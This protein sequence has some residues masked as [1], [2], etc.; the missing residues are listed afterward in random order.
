MKEDFLHYV[1]KFQKLISPRLRTVSWQRLPVLNPGLHN[2]NSGPDFFNAQLQLDGQLWAGNVEI[3]I[4]SSD[5]Y[6]HGHEKDPA[7]DSVILHVVWIHDAEV[8]R[9][10]GEVI[11][12]FEI[13]D[14]VEPL[15]VKKYN[16]LL[17]RAN[18]WI[19]CEQDFASIDDFTLHNWLEKLYFERLET[20]SELVLHHLSQQTN[21]WEAVLFQLLCK[22]FGLKVNG[23]S[24][25][26]IASSIPFSVIEKCRKNIRSLEALFFGEAGFLS[27]N[28]QDNYYI[29]LQR[30]YKY[31]QHKFKLQDQA[32]IQPK[33][34][35]LRPNNFPT[36]RLS[37]IASLYAKQEHLFSKIVTLNSKD[38]FY[39][40]FD[41][42]A[43]SYWDSHYNFG[44]PSST[45]IKKLSKK[46]IDLLLINTI[47][48]V[49]F[50]YALQQGKDNVEEL[51]V[52]AR[53]ISEEE[54]TT[55][56]KFNTLKQVA[57]QALESQA[58]LQLKTKYCDQNRCLQCAIG[59]KIL[60]KNDSN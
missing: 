6:A 59:N 60:N 41:V 4:Q 32:G 43:S 42:T 1:W 58:L 37:Q 13:Q 31:L 36:I 24:F 34:F 27:S 51:I 30:E 49:K 23:D 45:R 38:E 57:S 18:R 35:R 28:N 26:S 29:E 15:A 39:S 47:L 55:V 21:H 44:V 17:T 12:V 40:L 46:F 10:N 9:D 53:S 3:H 54:N 5:W 11:P 2:E 56:K 19:N 52:L 25:L 50:C 16:K 20:K 14:F 22:S 33:Y 8:I 7:Y 48:P